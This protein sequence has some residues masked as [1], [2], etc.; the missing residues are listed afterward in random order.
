MGIAKGTVYLHFA[1]K[2]DLLLAM[3][4]G[5]MDELYL[6]VREE[7]EAAGDALQALRQLMHAIVE[8]HLENEDTLSAIGD[9]GVRLLERRRQVSGYA[10]PLW[11]LVEGLVDRGK[12]MGVLNPE[13]HTV[14]AR[15]AL[16]RLSSLA[17]QR[18]HPGSP[19]L[20]GAAIRRSVTEI[21]LSGVSA[22]AGLPEAAA[23]RRRRAGR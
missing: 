4:D 17:L 21:Y 10:H 8:V 3:L 20:D 6:R 19:G 1:S 12:K 7:V 14:M 11:G 13:V 15:R 9:E 5:K 16:F 18:N 22:A 23:P 2:D